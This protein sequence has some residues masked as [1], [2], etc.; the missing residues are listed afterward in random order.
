MAKEKV[1]GGF[2]TESDVMI[3][4]L[5]ANAADTAHLDSRKQTVATLRDE[6]IELNKQQEAAKAQVQQL[7]AQIKAN[8]K[9]ARK[10]LS[11]L[12]KGVQAIYGDDVEKLEEFGIKV[13]S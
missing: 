9:A 3:S 10:E 12:R 1:L 2:L 4:A 13:K 6:L 8:L 11:L 5:E 7:T